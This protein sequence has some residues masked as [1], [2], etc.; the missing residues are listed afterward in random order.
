MDQKPRGVG[1]SYPVAV[2]EMACRCATLKAWKD[3]PPDERK[4][5]RTVVSTEDELNKALREAEPVWR[6]KVQGNTLTPLHV[7]VQLIK[8]L[9]DEVFLGGTG[10]G[11]SSEY[12]GGCILHMTYDEKGFEGWSVRSFEY[13]YRL[14][15]VKEKTETLALTHAIDIWKLWRDQVL[16]NTEVC[17][18]QTETITDPSAVTHPS[19][20]RRL[21]RTRS[22]FGSSS[23]ETSNIAFPTKVETPGA[24]SP[25]SDVVGAG[26]TSL[27]HHRRSPGAPDGTWDGRSC[28]LGLQ[29]I[30]PADGGLSG[31]R[32]PT[33]G[34]TAATDPLTH[35]SGTARPVA[36]MQSPLRQQQQPAA[37]ATE[38]HP[39]LGRRLSRTRSDFGSSSSETR[40]IAF[41]TKVETPPSTQRKS[42]HSDVV[43]ASGTARSVAG[44]ES[45]LRHQQQPAAIATEPSA[46]PMAGAEDTHI[47]DIRDP[48]DTRCRGATS[49]YAGAFFLSFTMIIGI[50]M[51]LWGCPTLFWSLFQGL[52]GCSSCIACSVSM[53]HGGCETVTKGMSWCRLSPVSARPLQALCSSCYA[54]R[55]AL[56]FGGR[57]WSKVWR[58]CGVGRVRVAQRTIVLKKPEWGE[59]VIAY[60]GSLFCPR[61]SA[62][63]FLGLFPKCSPCT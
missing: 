52:V 13:L 10:M 6:V 58:S 36:G 26:G 30:S 32:S 14:L 35:A 7:I 23:S 27:A 46:L 9:C 40:N 60:P 54:L 45:P 44:M 21:S 17:A 18:L 48:I 53:R 3:M 15:G 25:H 31:P 43:G 47:S 42:P 41:P 38:P 57:V 19:L 20:V 29:K 61:V 49:E 2:C 34:A 4:L 1:M 39:S 24:K 11:M 63:P 8:R 50:S 28:E 22:D 55:K 12:D 33:Q 37:I 5:F 56:L 51:A 59:N 62:Y 16:P